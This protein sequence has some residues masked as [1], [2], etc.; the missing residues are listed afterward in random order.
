M[1]EKC[2]NPSYTLVVFLII[3]FYTVFFS[4][5]VILIHGE[6]GRLFYWY[7]RIAKY[8]YIYC[9]P[10]PR[11][12]WYDTHCGDISNSYIWDVVLWLRQGYQD[13]FW[14]YSKPLSC[15]TVLLFVCKVP[16]MKSRQSKIKAFL[17]CVIGVN[18]D[19]INNL[20]LKLGMSRI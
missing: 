14:E 13:Q 18:N 2:L 1:H 17:V 6:I 20:Y 19:I 8:I 15:K 12:N 7:D 5:Q 9:K 16:M 11:Y 4:L 3:A 10:I